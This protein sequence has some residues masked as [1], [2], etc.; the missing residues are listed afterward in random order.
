[1]K[2]CPFCAEPIQAEAI[3]CRFCGEWL[4]KPSPIKKATQAIARDM[5]KAEYGQDQ[6]SVMPI[7]FPKAGK[8]ITGWVF[9]LGGG[10]A[11]LLAFVFLL[12]CLGIYLKDLPTSA[13]RIGGLI[14]AAVGSW[15]GMILH[16]RLANGLS[17]ES[18]RPHKERDGAVTKPSMEILGNTTRTTDASG[19]DGHKIGK[20]TDTH[21]GLHWVL[22]GA[23]CFGA[24][25]LIGTQLEKFFEMDSDKSAEQANTLG[26]TAKSEEAKL[27]KTLNEQAYDL[28]KR[29]PIQ[30][31]N[32]SRLEAVDLL[33]SKNMRLYIRILGRASSQIDKGKLNRT[34]RPWL[35]KQACSDPDLNLLLK[36][37]A[38][39]SFMYS[40]NDSVLVAVIKITQSDCDF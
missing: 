10:V 32:T 12:L 36:K 30:M 4:D 40:G 31:G 25:M 29:L 26:A 2:K 18:S 27:I 38:T 20:N 6:I 35:T 33:P 28:N 22:I 17:Q 7:P 19:Q 24:L 23:A 5:K 21:K 3:K 1:V 16:K 14:S 39:L 13:G 9:I 8:S 15:S 34:V 11:G 37:G